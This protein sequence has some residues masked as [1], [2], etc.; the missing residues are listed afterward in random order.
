MPEI[1]QKLTASPQL[2]RCPLGCRLRGILLPDR[3]GVAGQ[4][5]ILKSVHLIIIKKM[6]NKRQHRNKRVTIRFTES[7]FNNLHGKY[8]QTTCRVFNDYL[9]NVI[10]NKPVIIKTRNA[11]LDD[12]MPV[13]VLLKDELNSIGNNFNQLV[14]RLH[15]LQDN[16][17]IKTWALLLS[18]IHI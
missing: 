5:T 3:S 11:S 18:L 8:A 15:V 17:E 13:F 16:S 14:K 12:I 4:R 2:A 1:G 6:E 10:F 7:E 9:R